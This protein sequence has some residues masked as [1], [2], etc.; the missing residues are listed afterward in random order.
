VTG[1][2]T[3]K[4]RG[5]GQVYLLF[6]A[7]LLLVLTVGGAVELVSMAVG[8]AVTELVL[9]LLPAI[10]FVQWKRVP[11]ATAM[12]WH[13]V[14]APAALLSVALGVTGWGV[15]AGIHQLTVPLL[16]EPPDMPGLQA[17]SWPQLL[18]ILV[19]AGL[20]PAFCEETLFRGAI[21]GVLVR[22]GAGRAVVVTS[23]LFGVYH[24]SPWSLVPAFFL[25]LL[26]GGLA[27]RTGSTV[28]SMLAHF[29]NNATAVTVG[30]VL[31]DRPESTSRVLMVVLAAAFCVTFAVFWWYTRG[32][33]RTVPALA[34][35]PAGLS[36]I[37]AWLAGV[38]AVVAVSAVAALVAAAI[39]LFDV[40]T[41]TD[42]ALEP[43]IHRGDVLIASTRHLESARFAAGQIIA[44]RHDGD[45][46]LRRIARVEGETVWIEEDSGEQAIPRDR[47]VGRVIQTIPMSR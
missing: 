18:L 6:A 35:V 1:Q 8:L 19:C 11:L 40:Y 36:R 22:R 15:A 39:A 30:F 47:I 37:V 44:V 10:L 33:A 24:L 21:Q 45:V 23:I 17:A 2:S 28:P 12:R 27:E 25:G 46:V 13:A 31:A 5:V 14:P 34:A 29:G 9:I 42:D 7:S 32:A 20:L 3:T 41:V 38:A 26:F 4:G 43:A 16:G